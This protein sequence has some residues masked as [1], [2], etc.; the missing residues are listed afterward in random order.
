MCIN[1]N[2]LSLIQFKPIFFISCNSCWY[3]LLLKTSHH[4][5]NLSSKVIFNESTYQPIYNAF[6]Y[7]NKSKAPPPPPPLI[8]QKLNIPLI[9]MPPN[10]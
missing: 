8:I 3:M 10:S 1:L 4:H 6:P 2:A 5:T 9:Y 7:I